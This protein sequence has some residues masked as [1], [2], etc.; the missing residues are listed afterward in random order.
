MSTPLQ[1]DSPDQNGLSNR[2]PPLEIFRFNTGQEDIHVARKWC[3][4][5]FGDIYGWG[6]T[7]QYVHVGEDIFESKVAILIYKSH[8]WPLDKIKVMLALRWL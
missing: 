4:A 7:Y 3:K 5:T 1:Q 6:L 2:Y 8:E